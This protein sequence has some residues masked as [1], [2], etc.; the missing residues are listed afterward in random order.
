VAS[1]FLALGVR[2]ILSGYD[3]L[4]FL[5]ALLL[6]VR[7][8]RDVVTTVTAFTAAHSMTLALAVLGFVQVPAAVVE[9]LIAASIVWV[10]LENL[11]RPARWIHVGRSPLRSGWSTVSASPGAL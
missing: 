8:L 4:L 10:G 7:R 5:G 6:G 1:Q 2:H 11:A 9:P 3:H